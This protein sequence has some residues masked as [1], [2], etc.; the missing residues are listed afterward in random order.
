MRG[1][2]APS[3]WA[4]ALRVRSANARAAALLAAIFMVFAGVHA[5]AH[6]HHDEEEHDG[7]IGCLALHLLA[8]TPAAAPGEATTLRTPQPAFSLRQGEGA[9]VVAHRA[10]Q[11]RRLPRGPPRQSVAF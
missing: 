3:P 2:F 5:A 8:E 1:A 11:G 9:R 10:A 7:A 6:D 4:V